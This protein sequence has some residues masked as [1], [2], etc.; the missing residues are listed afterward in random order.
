MRPSENSPAK[1]QGQDKQDQK[2]N[3]QDL[4]DV[5]RD[6]R[7]TQLLLNLAPA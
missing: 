5:R 6:T 3:K 1:D 2:D 4:D 7:S